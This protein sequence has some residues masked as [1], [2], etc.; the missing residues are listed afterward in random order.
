MALHRLQENRSRHLQTAGRLADHEAVSAGPFQQGVSIKS[1]LGAVQS[2]HAPHGASAFGSGSQRPSA[3]LIGQ[4]RIAVD[5]VDRAVD[6][7]VQTGGY[8]ARL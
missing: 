3:F 8:F 6:D 5:F 2:D 7:E 4:I 1:I